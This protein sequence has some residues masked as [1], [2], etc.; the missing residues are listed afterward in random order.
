MSVL[1][2]VELS[3]RVGGPDPLDL[4]APVSRLPSDIHSEVRDRYAAAARSFDS[5]GQS[6]CGP[7]AIELEPG[8]G[9]RL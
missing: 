4:G 5:G 1:T 6:C 7:T 3:G 8:V 2:C 9:S